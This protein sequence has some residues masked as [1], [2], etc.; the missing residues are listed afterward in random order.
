MPSGPAILG[1][2]PL[3]ERYMTT[4]ERSAPAETLDEYRDRVRAWAADHMTPSGSVGAP[5]GDD[6]VGDWMRENGLDPAD[7]ISRGRAILKLMSE[8]GYG[9]I[10]F[11]V[12]YGGQ[13]LP[14]TYVHAFNAGVQG[15]D[16][17]PFGQFNLT[18]GMNAPALIEFGTEEQKRHYLPRM[19]DG[20]DLWIQFL[21]E[22]TGG[23]DLASAIT[24]A[25]RD[26]DEWVV[27]GSKIWTSTADKADMGMCLVRTNWDAPKH[28]GMSVLIIPMNA[29]GLEIHPLR[30]VSGQTGFCQEF[31]TDVRVPA[32]ALLGDLHDGWNVASRLLVHER[33]VLNGGSDYF[34]PPGGGF[35]AMMAASGG[36]RRDPLLDLAEARGL[37]H[38]SHVR[39]LVAEAHVNGKV[40]GQ[41][42]PR[43]TAA[44]RSGSMPPAASSILKLINSENS[45][46]RSD[47]QMEIAGPSAV[48]WEAGDFRS[49]M[50]GI[51]YLSRQTASL[52]SGTSEIQ[53]NIISE[54]VLGLPREPSPDREMPFK[55]VRHNTMPTN[56][57]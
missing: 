9:G 43:V 11:P 10:A 25:D 16:F 49:Q 32:D 30:L 17:M 53:R 54:R 50:S 29:P 41:V 1:A 35:A 3:R 40:G 37:E 45:V 26:G 34:A 8:A 48:V 52:V 7:S 13:G 33:N 15:F 56:K 31:F 42:G 19:F 20:T 12:E 46:R 39:Q 21:S 24:R 4:T 57:G 47:I 18:L 44:M 27:N 38:D 6:K 36:S 14:I 28:R 55:D 23:S 22:P 51:G 2:A 5:N